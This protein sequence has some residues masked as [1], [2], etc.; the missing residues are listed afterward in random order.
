MSAL[1]SSR[2]RG[3]RNRLL[4]TSVLAALATTEIVAMSSSPPSVF[5]DAHRFEILSTAVVG[6]QSAAALAPAVRLDPPQPVAVSPAVD[7]PVGAPAPA[8]LVNTSTCRSDLS[9][10]VMTITIPDISYM[11]PVYAGGQKMLDAGAVTQIT[12]DAISSV[13]AD[14]PGGPGLLWLAG[15]RASHGGAFAAVPN[16]ADDALVTISDGTFTATYRIVRRAYVSISN[17]RVIDASGDATGAATIDSILR[18]DHGGV[19]G[20]SRLLLQ[21]CDGED[22]RW[23]IYADLVG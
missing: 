21:T 8:P 3:A 11:C 12:D 22:H 7:V 6:P 18:A 23:M 17:D 4:A 19:G 2:L 5:A 10:A 16:L 1:V 20:D 14:H 13:L 9:G 15:H